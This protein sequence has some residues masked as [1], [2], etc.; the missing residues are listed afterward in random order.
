M[1]HAQ[2]ETWGGVRPVQ[3]FAIAHC[4]CETLFKCSLCWLDMCGLLRNQ[5]GACMV[6]VVR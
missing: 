5:V 4:L 1:L 6:K 2:N 3:L